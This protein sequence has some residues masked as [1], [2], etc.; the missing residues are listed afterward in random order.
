MVWGR[1]DEGSGHSQHSGKDQGT[2]HQIES[3]VCEEM[4]E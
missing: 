2:H 4:I 3:P 1:G